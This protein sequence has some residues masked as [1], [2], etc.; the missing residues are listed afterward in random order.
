MFGFEGPHRGS[1]DE[2]GVFHFSVTVPDW[3]IWQTLTN[4]ENLESPILQV[5]RAPSKDSGVAAETTRGR[6][7]PW[8]PPAVRPPQLASH[9]AEFQRVEPVHL[10][11]GPPP[12]E[13]GE[14][15]TKP[16]L[17]LEH[18]KNP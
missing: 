3:W 16:S 7:H 10:G 1:F 12:G 9:P 15:L 4:C 11:Q 14:C 6:D 17:Q 5:T 8:S 13:A 18:V 2:Q